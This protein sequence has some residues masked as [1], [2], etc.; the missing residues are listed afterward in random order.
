MKISLDYNIS[1][2][3]L[4]ET[5]LRQE[6]TFRIEGF[7]CLRDDRPA[8]YGGAA[9]LIRDNLPF[10]IIPIKPPL[11]PFEIV[12]ARIFN[13]TFLSI[14]ISPSITQESITYLKKVLET[15]PKPLVLLADLNMHHPLWG[16]HNTDAP[17][18]RMVEYL[19]DFDLC[20]LNDGSPTRIPV[21]NQQISIPDLSITS[22]DVA[23]VFCWRTLE[24]VGGSDH[25][26]IL[27]EWSS[28]EIRVRKKL[29]RS[30]PVT[31]K[32]KQINRK[33]L[34]NANWGGFN[35]FCDETCGS[36]PQPTNDNINE[37][38]DSLTK[39]FHKLPKFQNKTSFKKSP[40]PFVP[41]WDDECEKMVQNRR[42]VL[43]IYQSNSD[44]ENFI[45]LKNA[46]AQAKR[47]FRAKKKA[48]WMAFCNSLS[49][50][51][52]ISTVWSNI[53]KF[54]GTLKN[55]KT[56]HIAEYPFSAFIN[57][58]APSYAPNLEEI[59]SQES[60]HLQRDTTASNISSSAQNAS[61]HSFMVSQF[62]L[63]E[64]S[65]VLRSVR[66]S[67]PGPDE[68]PYSLL[69]KSGKSTITYLLKLMNT[70]FDNCIVPDAW[71]SQVI[72]P[73]P[74]NLSNV[75]EDVAFRPIALSSVLL[76]VLEHMIKRRLDW[77]AEKS[78]SFS[79][80][81]FGFRKGKS[82]MES[83]AH[84]V[85]DILTAFSES[86]H[87][88][89]VSLD[90]SG[91]YDNVLLPVLGDK[92]RKLGVP[93]K[94]VSLLHCM[95]SE[96]NILVEGPGG[97][98]HNRTVYRGLPQGSVISPLLFNIYIHDVF[99][100]LSSDIKL[101]N[102]A[103]DFFVYCVGNDINK[104]EDTMNSNLRILSNKLSCLGLTFN[105]SKCKTIIFSK[106]RRP[107]PCNIYIND[108]PLPQTQELKF[109]GVTL[110]TKLTWN[111]AT[112]Y[113][114]NRC[115]AGLNAMRAVS[116]VWWGSHPRILKLMYNSLIR[117]QLDYCGFLMS[118]L[119]KTNC[120]K[121]D[122]VQYEALRIVLGAMKSS[123]VEALQVE[124]AE[125]PLDIRRQYLADK[126]FIRSCI[127]SDN[128]IIDKIRYLY[129]IVKK[130]RRFWGKKSPPNLVSSYE[131]L[132]SYVK[133]IK[134]YDTLPIYTV[135]YSSLN[136]RPQ[137]V[138]FFSS[139][140]VSNASV[141]FEQIIN[142][143]WKEFNRVF[144]DGS[145]DQ[146]AMSTGAAVFSE[147]DGHKK[148]I[149]LPKELSIF[150]AEC[151]AILEALNNISQNNLK[152]TII[153]SDSLSA[154]QKIN[155]SSFNY[156]LDCTVLQIKQLLH[157]LH[158][159]G[160]NVVL[161]WIPGHAGIRGNESADCLAKE[162]SELPCSLTHQSLPFS[163]LFFTCREHLL[164]SWQA[165]WN[166]SPSRYKHIQP[167]I[168][169]IP[170]YNKIA[171]AR[172]STSVICRIKFGHVCTKQFLFKIGVITT[173]MCDCGEEEESIN[174][175]F[176]SCKDRGKYPGF[177]ADLTKLKV[178]FPTSMTALLSDFN[179]S[180]YNLI[181][182]FIIK[183]SVK[184]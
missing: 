6:K 29:P 73:I 123:P 12:G 69:H 127:L 138:K 102:Y 163:D 80:L 94:M 21:P 132:N 52:P 34:R 1:I 59:W 117:S 157:N 41:W 100:G 82:T 141:K 125:P 153:L 87:A 10:S 28:P 33:V 90:I 113:C 3:A 152:N 172:Q 151:V 106:A 119:S 120:K 17:G 95:L 89:G 45:A 77:F 67:A 64:L 44:F 161:G 146:T 79:P 56:K 126:F 2:M 122:R 171:L 184:I 155:N 47:L 85:T 27:L 9:L 147:Y 112:S 24:E 129:D 37:C 145:K 36:L 182:K 177:I 13:T 174:H 49:P 39:M 101:L 92:L 60:S 118:P 115:Q 7:T 4:S 35:E 97:T 156:P 93:S 173:D 58:L 70:C 183:N 133:D 42:E 162:A 179:P 110:D 96:R 124:A 78:K 108:C 18:R 142:K 54:R 81:M 61:E 46:Q 178:P 165:R 65:S 130:N 48:G 131:S 63:E 5:W 134:R 166:A 53:R 137:V 159:R 15:S 169:R 32:K 158:Q 68:I 91:A 38:S 40:Q 116:R 66:D 139:K 83:V 107:K 30:N 98:I 109:L 150:S 51:T 167:T 181:S 144:T 104:T 71:K 16:C 25:F 86:K 20:V 84:L 180:I 22:S 154:M 76:K 160:C 135:T 114:V 175:I 19:N 140:H 75:P 111:A 88:V 26:P 43:K 121:M 74:K 143:E 136:Y 62:S 164:E 50:Q 55:R 105:P 11:C 170:W 57:K 23:S 8:G 72:I 14:Y 103:D 149:A 176:F 128:L 99:E 31:G 148:R 168:N